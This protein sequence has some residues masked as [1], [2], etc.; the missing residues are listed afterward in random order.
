MRPIDV[1]LEN[2]QEIWQR[3]YRPHV[4]EMKKNREEKLKKGDI[5]RMGRDKGVFEKGFLPNYSD[6]LVTIDWIKRG[7][8]NIYNLKD[9][10]GESFSSRFYEKELSKTRRDTTYRI[11]KILD[12]RVRRG[13]KEHL[14]KF[15]DYKEPEWIKESDIEK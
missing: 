1:T 9:D 15:I 13:I 12:T 4:D 3:V 2:S 11:E 7:K 5:V 10:R 8:P 14:V 6:E